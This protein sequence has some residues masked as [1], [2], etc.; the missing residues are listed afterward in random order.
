MRPELASHVRKQRGVFRRNQATGSGYSEAEVKRHIRSGAWIAV[1]HGIYTTREKHAEAQ[2]TVLGVHLLAAAAAMLALGGDI[3]LSHESAAAFHGMH[4]LDELPAEPQLTRHRAGGSAVMTAHGHHVASVPPEHRFA[5][6]PVVSPARAVV[7]CL[8]TLR[9]DAGFVTV[10]SALRLGLD[11]NAVL[12]ALATC[13]GWPG[14]AEAR[15]LAL[16][17]GPWSESPL[18]SRARL[19]FW[20]QGLPQ[21]SQQMWVAR[22][23]GSFV[24]RVDFV[25]P[26]FRTVFEADGQVKYGDADEAPD[27]ASRRTLWQEKLREDRLRD[28]GLEVVRGYWSDGEDEGA[29]LAGRLRRAF[30]RGRRATEAPA[31][32][33]ICPDLSPYRPLAVAG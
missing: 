11:R 10:E 7:D 28:L 5:A 21:P 15:A 24:A 23:A 29:A 32:R 2:T 12:D 19:W 17:A 31:Y 9:P 33:L 6:G 22:P 3:V 13:A 18:E 16:H 20:R 1:R 14:T 26:E 30:V 8:R 4:L 25:W 27:D